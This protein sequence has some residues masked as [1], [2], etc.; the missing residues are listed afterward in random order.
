MSL[1]PPLNETS[2]NGFR[3]QRITEI[4]RRLEKERNFRAL[5][6]KKYQRGFNIMMGIDTTLIAAGI[7]LGV[8]GIFAGPLLIALET[9]AGVCSALG[10]ACKF[11][12]KP[13]QLKAKKHNEIRVLAESKINTVSSLV[14]KALTDNKISD[15][16]FNLIMSELNKYNALKANIQSQLKG[17]LSLTDAE[18]KEL[19]RKAKTPE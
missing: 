3:L 9:T 11:M 16:E 4:Q 19:I 1:Y 14:S 18:K 15:E 12:S 6:Y 2:P 7:S 17:Q 10:I 8:A 5:L 13:L